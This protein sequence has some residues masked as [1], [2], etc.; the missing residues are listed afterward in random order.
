MVL[1][2]IV[3]D[4]ARLLG[5]GVVGSLRVRH[6]G[7][8]PRN[9]SGSFLAT[10]PKRRGKEW[11]EVQTAGKCRRRGSAGGGEVQTAGKR[12]RR[13]SA[14]GGANPPHPLASGGSVACDRG[15]FFIRVGSG[16]GP[17]LNAVS[18]TSSC[19]MEKGKLMEATSPFTE[20]RPSF[21]GIKIVRRSF[22]WN[23]GLCK[24]GCRSPRR[25]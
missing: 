16:A 4:Q 9:P 18:F 3:P 6:T 22:L 12:R 11:R 10:S 15:G 14:G 1:V 2:T 23:P 24:K 20:S 7:I 8:I 25:L 5:G 21:H 17:Y 13:G 19:A